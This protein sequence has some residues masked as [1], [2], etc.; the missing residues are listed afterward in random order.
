MT[1][2]ASMKKPREDS[3]LDGLPDEQKQKLIEWM[4]RNQGYHT[5]IALL[6]KEFGVDTGLRALSKFHDRWIKPILKEN[7]RNSAKMAEA[8]EAEMQKN[9]DLFD[10]ATI[11]NLKRAAFDLSCDANFDPA[12][13][14]NLLDPLLKRDAL[15]LDRQKFQFDAAKA[16]LEKADELA[17]IRGDVTLDETG[18]INAA[19]AQ[20]FGEV[21]A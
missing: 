18:R 21:A 12:A 19:R 16:A 1:E 9:P 3:K 14:K 10:A 15:N 11:K 4:L 2:A 5:I 6:K 20:L 13:M 7:I 17:K 8:I